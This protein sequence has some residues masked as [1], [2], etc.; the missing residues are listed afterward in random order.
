MKREAF[1]PVNFF[2][3]NVRLL[4]GVVELPKNVI[5]RFLT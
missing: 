1:K 3:Y 2:I 5:Y 4:N